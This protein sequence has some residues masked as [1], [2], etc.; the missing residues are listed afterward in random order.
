MKNAYLGYIGLQKS[1]FSYTGS[2]IDLTGVFSL[3][4][5]YSLKREG[6]IDKINPYTAKKYNKTV[7]HIIPGTHGDTEIIDG[8]GNCKIYNIIEQQYE[9]SNLKPTQ[10]YVGAYYTSERV[11]YGPTSLKFPGSS[12]LFVLYNDNLDLSSG[13]WTIE[14]WEYRLQNNVG[15]PVIIFPCAGN[16]D[17]MLVGY[18]QTTGYNMLYL[19]SNAN[20]W[21]VG[22]IIGTSSINT[23]NHYAVVRKTETNQIFGFQNGVLRST[24]AFSGTTTLVKS[25]SNIVLCGFIKA[26]ATQY[27]FV[28]YI[29]DLKIS[30]MAKYSASFEPTRNDTNI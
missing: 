16:Y 2:N 9:K 1:P 13:S 22:A 23:W 27:T 20:G 12:S 25:N 17:A 8:T 18:S 5:H 15:A 7:L 6:Y 21:N 28:G 14:W 29:E 24:T 4:E 11:K 3:D 26:A 10:E 19:S 30:K